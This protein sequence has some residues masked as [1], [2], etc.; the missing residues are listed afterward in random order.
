MKAGE[1]VTLFMDWSKGLV[2]MDFKLLPKAYKRG[3]EIYYRLESVKG[4]QFEIRLTKAQLASAMK[5]DE[6]KVTSIKF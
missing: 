5:C 6:V 2:I 3:G 1:I 4:K